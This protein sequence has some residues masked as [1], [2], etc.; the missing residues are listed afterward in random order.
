MAQLEALELVRQLPK[1]Q[2]ISLAKELEK[3]LGESKLTALLSAFKTDA[4]TLEEITST[5]EDVRQARYEARK[6]Y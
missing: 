2:K 1:P 4:L 6:K 5:V 3:E